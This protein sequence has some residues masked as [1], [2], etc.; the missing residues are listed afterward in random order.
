[1]QISDEH[2]LL[3]QSWRTG[4]EYILHAIRF[5][6]MLLFTVQFHHS[7]YNLCLAEGHA[8]LKHDP[9]KAL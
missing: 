4:N 9:I 8:T 3:F 1:M 6:I 2:H 5:C 7:L